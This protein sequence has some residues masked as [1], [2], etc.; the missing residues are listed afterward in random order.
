MAKAFKDIAKLSMATMGS[1][2]LGLVRDSASM[3]YIGLGAVSA[4][5]TFAFTLPN[6]FRRLLGEGALTSAMVPIFTQTLNE[7]GKEGAFGFLNKTLSRAGLI[8]TAIVVAGMLLALITLH[9]ELSQTERFELGAAYSIILMPYM[10]LICMAAVFTAALNVLG[11]F[12]IPAI[13][14]A[15]LNIMIILGTFTGVY[16]FGNNSELIAYAMCGGWLAGGFLQMAIPAIY[17]R[18]FGWR[19]KFDLKG[20]AALSELWRLFLPAC[21]GAAV[22]QLNIFASKILALFISNDALPSLYISSRMLELPLGVFAIA[23]AT[24]Y[25]PKL[26]S[27]SSS[28][29]TQGYRREYKFGLIVT[30][31]ISVPATLGLVTLSQDILSTLFQWGIFGSKDVEICTPVMVA[32]VMG[33]P[34]F[35][36]ATF[37]TRGFHSTKDTKIPMRACC[38]S[39]AVNI[40]LSLILMFKYGAVGLASANVGAAILQSAYLT[41]YLRKKFGNFGAWGSIV[42]ITIASILMAISI[43]GGKQ[44]TASYFDGRELAVLNCAIFIPIGCLLYLLFLKLV[45]FEQLDTLLKP[46][47][48]KFRK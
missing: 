36:L 29:D 12:G 1:R 44:L 6:L 28:K 32:A 9:T 21:A 39:F 4:A 35:A 34:F 14:P 3:A 46:V 15:A 40:I 8:F 31:A 41:F 18:K 7:E 17:L 42:K 19:F 47:L 10:F 26:S 11:S 13:G 48:K 23:V 37:A 2:I 5:Y 27:L 38:W 24:V 30:M 16:V 45:E 33:L 43:E 20:S 22:I 25:F